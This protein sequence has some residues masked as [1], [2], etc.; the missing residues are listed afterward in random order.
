MTLSAAGFPGSVTDVQWSQLIDL[1]GHDGTDGMNVSVASGDRTVQISSGRSNVGG[2]LA[3]N[4]SALT[5]GPLPANTGSL[6]RIDRIILRA[7]WSNKLLQATWRTGT[8]SSNPQPPTLRKDPGDVYEVRLAQVVM[9]PG[10]GNLSSGDL[11][12]EKIPPVSGFYNSSGFRGFPDAENGSLVWYTAANSLRIPVDGEYVE[13]ANARSEMRPD[14]AFS[15]ADF[16]YTSS[17]PSATTS[18]AGNVGRSFTAPPSGMV[19]V[20]VTGRIQSNINGNLAL[21]GWEM[22]T[23]ASLGG[24]S[25]V[26]A[27]NANRALIAGESVNTGA[28][29]V[30]CAT[31]RFL[32]TG[33]SPSSVYHVRAM[34]WSSS[35]GKTSQ[36][37]SRGIVIEP[38]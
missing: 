22:R 31:N 28:P 4:D 17:T 30:V 33:L 37:W 16:T 19:F 18:G 26:Y 35:S 9:A 23:G 36:Y 21:L 12:A 14:Q 15:D 20:S 38:V 25:Q 29:N 24:G 13:I 11:R 8:P 5:V 32:A 2:V 10:T 3:T 6:T 7:N 1:L 34:H 27:P